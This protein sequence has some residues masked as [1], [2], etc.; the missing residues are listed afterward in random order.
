[1]Q[2]ERQ[3]AKALREFINLRPRRV[4]DTRR[5][6]GEYLRRS[7]NVQWVER[8]QRYS[9]SPYSRINNSTGNDEDARRIRPQ[10][11]CAVGWAS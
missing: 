9:G 7:G 11:S 5:Q 2:R 4:C 3:A 6:I 8:T 10:P 1:M